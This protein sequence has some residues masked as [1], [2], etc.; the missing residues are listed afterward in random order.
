[1]LERRVE[2]WMSHDVLTLRSRSTVREALELME[3]ERIRHILVVEKDRVEGIVSDRDVKRLLAGKGRE[4]IGHALEHPLGSIMTKNVIHLDPDAT[5][6]E[7]AEL[8]C[9][10]KV[11]AL[12]ILDGEYL[13][14]IITSEDVLWAF[15]ELER[16]DEDDRVDAEIARSLPPESGVA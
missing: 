11:S 15:V 12:P 1:M 14:G 10:E 2:R 13:E 5:L 9:H 8:M 6:V 16:S 3:R 7:A 4:S